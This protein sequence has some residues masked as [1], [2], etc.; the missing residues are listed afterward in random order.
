MSDCAERAVSEACDGAATG[1]RPE[2]RLH[3]HASLCGEA[4]ENREVVGLAA[5]T[6]DAGPANDVKTGERWTSSVVGTKTAS[7]TARSG[8][9][10][11]LFLVGSRS[12]VSFGPQSQAST[13][14]FFRRGRG[15]EPLRLVDAAG[16]WP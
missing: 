5:V 9:S 3:S 10:R 7:P 4:Q 14:A 2:G 11:R 8:R 13:T 12:S 1:R 15:T 6:L 16:D